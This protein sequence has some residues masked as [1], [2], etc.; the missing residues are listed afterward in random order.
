LNVLIGIKLEI[1]ALAISTVPVLTGKAAK[2]FTE[3]M[4][5][6]EQKRGSVDFSKQ[7]AKARKILSKAKF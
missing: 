5:A 1:M 7:I 4:K 3:K 6:S 2:R